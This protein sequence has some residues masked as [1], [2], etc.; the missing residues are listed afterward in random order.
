[1][2]TGLNPINFLS[3]SLLT[4]STWKIEKRIG[5]WEC[6]KLIFNMSVT[7][8]LKETGETQCIPSNEESWCLVKSHS[9]QLFGWQFHQLWLRN[10]HLVGDG[11]EMSFT[12]YQPLN[13]A[14]TNFIITPDKIFFNSKPWNSVLSFSSFFVSR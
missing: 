14:L 2:K 13:V 8:F 7:F 9:V 6:I 4:L 1:M 11:S 10:D 12:I 5:T 3:T